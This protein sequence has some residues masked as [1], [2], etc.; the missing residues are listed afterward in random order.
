V[1]EQLELTAPSS[2]HRNRV[3]E[4]IVAWIRTHHAWGATRHEVEM[5]FGLKTQTTC[6]R[7]REAEQLGEIGKTGRKREGC[8]VYAAV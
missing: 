5:A 6:W 3:R 7:L 4:A 8:T 1:S 2:L